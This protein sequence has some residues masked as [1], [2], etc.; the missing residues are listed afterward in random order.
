MAVVGWP[1]GEPPSGSM[2]TAIRATERISRW[3]G[4]INIG[5]RPGWVGNNPMDMGFLPGT[6]A[7]SCKD[8]SAGK[9]MLRM[10]TKAM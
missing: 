10:V 8:L 7:Q 1:V 5:V 9:D 6:M 4:V 2:V 3:S